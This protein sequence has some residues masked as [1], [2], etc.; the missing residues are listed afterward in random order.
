MVHVIVDEQELHKQA[1]RQVFN[2]FV[3]VMLFDYRG[4]C[5]AFCGCS[6][7]IGGMVAPQVLILVSIFRISSQI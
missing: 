2:H 7:R 6:L 5:L 3:T 1:Q 4:S